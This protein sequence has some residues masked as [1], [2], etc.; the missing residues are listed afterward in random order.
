MRRSFRYSLA[1]MAML[2]FV[3]AC[4]ST[5]TPQGGLAAARAGVPLG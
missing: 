1:L 2:G 4:K 3:V 5:T